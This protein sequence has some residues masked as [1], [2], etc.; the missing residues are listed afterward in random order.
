M[1]RGLSAIAA[2]A[3]VAASVFGAAACGSD[4]DAGGGGGGA[5]KKGGSIKIGTVGPDNHDPALFQTIQAVQALQLVYT[6]LTTYAHEEG[7][8][9]GELIPGLAE[10]LPTVTNGGKTYKYTL[11]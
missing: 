11:R 3:L 4:D 1:K 6:P 9:G 8:A 2:P 10:K 5:G 7:K